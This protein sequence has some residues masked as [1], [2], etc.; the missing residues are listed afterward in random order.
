LCCRYQCQRANT[1]PK[2]KVKKCRNVIWTTGSS[3]PSSRTTARRAVASR[4]MRECWAD[5][6][7]YRVGRKALALVQLTTHPPSPSVP[8][9]CWVVVSTGMMMGSYRVSPVPASNDLKRCTRCGGGEAAGRIHPR[10]LSEGWP[11]S[12]VKGCVRRWQQANSEHLADYHRRWQQANVER[13]RETARRYRD[14]K[15]ED[16]AYRERRRAQDRPYR[17]RKRARLSNTPPEANDG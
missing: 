14:R 5:G 1:I 7:G 9:R 17:A 11:R 13:K 16:P 15:R 6:P 10:P 12:V 8:A 3:A 4:Q 2:K